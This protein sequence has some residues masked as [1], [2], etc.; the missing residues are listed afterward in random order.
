MLIWIVQTAVGISSYFM[1]NDPLVYEKPLEF[2]PERWLGDVDPNMMRNFTP[3]TR[4]LVAKNPRASHANRIQGSR[5]CIG[6]NLALAELSLALAVL[7]RP[8]GARLELYETD[9]T[10]TN[11]VHDFGVPLP[12]LETKGVRVTVH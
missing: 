11:H 6:Q 12:K 4:G 5:N 3:F 8:G 9:E 1:H 2:V 10:D 7:F